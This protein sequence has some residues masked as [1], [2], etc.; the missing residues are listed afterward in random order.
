MIFRVRYQTVTVFHRDMHANTEKRDKNYDAKQSNFDDIRDETLSR[1]F[2]IFYQWK[3]KPR[4]KFKWG[5]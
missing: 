3:Q 4:G 2:D 5:S 1:I